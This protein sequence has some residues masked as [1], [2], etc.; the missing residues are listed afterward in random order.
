MQIKT[1]EYAHYKGATDIFIKKISAG[2]ISDVFRGGLICSLRETLGALAY[3]TVYENYIRSRLREGEVS[4]TQSS[5][6]DI[7]TAGSLA[8]ICYWFMIYPLDSIKTQI[9]TGNCK[10]YG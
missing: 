5:N 4:H 8:G 7:I 9:Q 6:L 1:P 3:F 2:Q 10:T